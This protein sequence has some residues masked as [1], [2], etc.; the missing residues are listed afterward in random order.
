MHGMAVSTYVPDVM[1]TRRQMLHDF[2]FI[3][4]AHVYQPQSSGVFVSP[5]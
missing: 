5:D 1:E 2:F 3:F 4:F